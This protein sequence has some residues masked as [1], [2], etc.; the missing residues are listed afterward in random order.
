MMLVIIQASI[1]EMIRWYQLGA[2][3]LVLNPKPHTINPT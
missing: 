3:T 1:A 2:N